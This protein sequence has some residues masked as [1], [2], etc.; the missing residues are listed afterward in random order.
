MFHKNDTIPALNLKSLF[1]KSRENLIN[2]ALFNFVIIHDSI[3]SVKELYS[4]IYVKIDFVERWY[5]WPLPIFEISGRNFNSW[6]KEKDFSKVNYGVFLIKENFRGRKETIKLLLRFGYD[7]RYGISYEKPY[8]NRSQ[9]VGAGLGAGWEQNHEIA[10]KTEN[11]ELIFIKS[12]NG[13]L[14]KHF[15]SY[16]N[17]LLRPSIYSHHILQLNFNHYEFA[18]T[19]LKL[20]PDYSFD[21][22]NINEYLTLYYRFSVDHR[23]NNIY[24]LKGNYY[25]LE[26]S[27]S[28]F[29]VLKNGDV[30]M[31]ELKGS[32]RK[33]WQ[34]YKR[35]FYSADISAKISTNRDQP[36]FFQKGLGYDRNYLRG[37]ELYVIDGQSYW[38]IK[39]NLK[40]N[41]LP[42]KVSNIKFIKSEKFGKIH[43]AIYLSWFFDIGYVDAY[44][45]YDVNSLNN[46]LLYGT[47]F[48]LDFVTYYDIVFRLEFSVN[49]SGETGFYFH[50][51]NTL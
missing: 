40:Y 12:N 6:W 34:I 33:Y 9:T 15:Y 19:V 41:L 20:N 39:T 48:C 38:L 8:I 18:D 25:D 3:I 21:N 31:I 7:E 11:N 42:T 35:F 23:N 22:E 43:Y 27:K 1:E 28:G 36:Y 46:K 47:G 26:I 29:G 49:K 44:K 24:P 13:Y 30:S 50:L 14:F 51:K 16:L 37:Y 32:Y 10:Y 5:L 45:N 2:T 17:V 4:H